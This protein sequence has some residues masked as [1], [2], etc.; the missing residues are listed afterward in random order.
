MVGSFKF[1]DRG[2]HLDWF[3]QQPT[4]ADDAL[5]TFSTPFELPSSAELPATRLPDHRHRYLDYD[6]EISSD[7]GS[8]QRLVTGTYRLVDDH[9]DPFAFA[10]ESVRLLSDGPFAEK[11]LATFVL[12]TRQRIDLIVRV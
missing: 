8:V 6:G 3:F 5:W 12:P 11:L 9:D 7:R 2:D 1:A 10:V 4:G